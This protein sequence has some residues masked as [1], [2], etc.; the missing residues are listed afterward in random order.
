MANAKR[1]PYPPALRARAVRLVAERPEWEREWPAIERVAQE[2]GIGSADTVRRWVHQ[3]EAAEGLR[4]PMKSRDSR[5]RLTNHRQPWTQAED[6]ILAAFNHDREKASHLLG[7]KYGALIHRARYLGL[8][9]KRS[10]PY[11]YARYWQYANLRD[12]RFTL[13]SI[14]EMYGVSAAAVS[15]VLSA[16]DRDAA[17]GSRA[18]RHPRLEECCL[19]QRKP[20]RLGLCSMHYHRLR[21]GREMLADRPRG[22]GRGATAEEISLVTKLRLK[23]LTWKEVGAKI[24]KSESRA[25]KLGK[26][27]GFIG[28]IEQP[29]KHGI[30]ARWQAGC[31][32]DLCVR[33]MKEYKQA[34]HQRA[35]QRAADA[36][37]AG[38]HLPGPHC[39]C[40]ECRK[41]ASDKLAAR[42]DRTKPGA[43]EHYQ[44]WTEDEDA[45]A[46]DH[47]RRIEDIA[48]DLGRTYAA[49]DNRRRY[50]AR[51]LKT[52]RDQDDTLAS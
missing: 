38:E 43:V 49:V 23:G 4:P 39:P 20:H 31:R 30:P 32:C 18:F 9:D 21:A 47:S 41:A 37:E 44:R 50:L 8:P 51:K 33:S 3:S 27:A 22:G 24:G 34:A 26:Q 52:Q 48:T 42:L 15:K 7:R 28:A 46:M 35:R 11:R 36:W 17:R 5:I 25:A 29:A 40:P 13:A 16:G 19:C 10:K 12:R 14:A 6:E 1:K 2:L 45:I